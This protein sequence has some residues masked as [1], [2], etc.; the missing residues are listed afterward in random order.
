M[1]NKVGALFIEHLGL[2]AGLKIFVN[3]PPDA[4]APDVFVEA[5]SF[6]HRAEKRAGAGPVSLLNNAAIRIHDVKATVRPRLHIHGAKVRV[7]AADEFGIWV[8]VPQRGDAILD[9]H[10]AAPNQAPDRL[11]EEHVPSRILRQSVAAKDF[12]PAGSGEMVERKVVLAVT[13][14]AALHVAQ[15]DGRPHGHPAFFKL[16]RHIHRAV[17]DMRLEVPHALFAARIG[18]PQLPPII[19]RQP[20]LAA[21]G[22]GRLLHGFAVRRPAK[23][24]GVVGRV[25]PIIHRPR[26]PA[27]LVLHVPAARPAFVKRTLFLGNSVPVFVAPRDDVVCVCLPD[28]HLVL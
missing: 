17:R 13:P 23:P 4:P 10:D 15:A 14:G 18:E 19:L 12:L 7:A 20:P 27:R 25:E 24:V 8:R 2:R 6:N 22:R 16:L 28:E 9:L 1:R 26:E 3:E 11:G 5:V 21:I